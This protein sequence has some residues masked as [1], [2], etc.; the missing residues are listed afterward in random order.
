MRDMAVELES[1]YSVQVEVA[2]RLGS[3]IDV[4]RRLGP[5]SPNTDGIFVLSD[6]GVRRI[7][8]ND[9]GVLSVSQPN[10]API[11]LAADEPVQ[12]VMGVPAELRTRDGG[13][14]ELLPRQA[15]DPGLLE[16]THENEA[17]VLD[18][19][20]ASAF[21]RYFISHHP[22]LEPEPEVEPNLDLGI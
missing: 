18:G 6:T 9:D 22:R 15:L 20:L 14:V 7:F 1:G 17:R 2:L 11:A 19:S 8:R 16:V 12:L 10:A 4:S 13:T 21:R 5:G 3:T